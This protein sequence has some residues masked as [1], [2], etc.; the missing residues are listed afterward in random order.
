M[1]QETF[2]IKNSSNLLRADYDSLTESITIFFKNGSAYKFVGIDYKLFEEL[3][4]AESAGKFFTDNI[5][6]KYEFLKLS[7]KAQKK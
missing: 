6:N 4:T 1:L 5:K 2:V 7:E 3:K